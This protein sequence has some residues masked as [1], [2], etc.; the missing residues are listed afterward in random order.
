LER[1]EL[2]Q[3]CWDGVGRDVRDTL[4]IGQQRHLIDVEKALGEPAGLV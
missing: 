3:E 1:R 4:G 2:S